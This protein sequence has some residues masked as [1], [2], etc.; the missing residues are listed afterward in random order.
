M[1][2]QIVAKQIHPN[3]SAIL[4]SISYDAGTDCGPAAGMKLT[5]G[6]PTINNGQKVVLFDQ[7]IKGQRM[8]LKYETRPELAAL[9]AEWEAIEAEKQAKREFE[10]KIKRLAEETIDIPL[11][12]A[13]NTEADRLRG[14]IPRENIEVTITQ[15]GDLDGDP[16]LKYEVDGFE[17]SWSDVTVHGWATAIRPG[18]MG[19]FKSVCVA[20]IN[21]A[22]LAELMTARDEAEK[23]EIEATQKAEE[24]KI[25]KFE[26]AKTTGEKVLLRKWTADCND[27]REECNVD[28]ITE[29]AMP[30]GTTKTERQHTW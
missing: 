27:H 19:A 1:A 5:G 20:S 22:K 28:I 6:R 9:V 2:N 7:K 25:R 23:A 29:W 8:G 12:A 18:A 24:E 14:L 17:I 26:T 21:L 10:W 15:T 30:D 16:I 3:E 11:V 13:M 4:H